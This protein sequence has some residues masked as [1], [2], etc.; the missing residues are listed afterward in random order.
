MLGSLKEKLGFGKKGEVLYAPIEGEVIELAKVSD[1]TFGEEILGKG[2]AIVPSVGKV[3]A[4]I[5]ATV[6]M[7]FDTKHAISMKSESGIEILVHVGLDTVTLKGEPFTEHVKAGDKVKAGD[8]LLEFDID[9]IKNAGLEVVSPV[10]ICN[11]A[12][13]SEIKTTTGKTVGT[14][15]E[16]MTIIK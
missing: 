12:D 1:P 15:D 6:E 3:Y 7:V 2:V 8:L 16:V 4:P 13:Y 9:A 14:K 5:D 10:I 11:T